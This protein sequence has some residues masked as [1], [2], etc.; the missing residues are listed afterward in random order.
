MPE[1]YRPEIP[2]GINYT[3]IET[4]SSGTLVVGVSGRRIVVTSLW[5]VASAN[6]NV[7][8]Q[9]FTGSADISGPA[10]CVANGGIVLGFNA[11]GWFQTL[12]GDSLLIN[13]SAGVPVGGSLSYIFA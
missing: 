9:T 2:T 7:K 10:Y 1:I 6:V 13:L 5:V 4:A 8:F 12:P 3:P 11:G